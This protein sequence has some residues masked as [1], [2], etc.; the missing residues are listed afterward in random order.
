MTYTV[1]CR[2][3]TAGP[4]GAPTAAPSAVLSEI[5]LVFVPGRSHWLVAGATVGGLVLP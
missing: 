3:L 4:D 2:T 1:G 5:T